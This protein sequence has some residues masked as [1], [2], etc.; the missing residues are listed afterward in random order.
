V[1]QL[2]LINP[3][4]AERCDCGYD[5]TA[6]EMKESYLEPRERRLHARHG[7]GM[8]A[9]VLLLLAVRIFGM[10]INQYVLAKP[11]E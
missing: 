2:Q 6:G 1:S 10:L 8:A 7:A 4:D 11:E 3:N 9:V 5:F